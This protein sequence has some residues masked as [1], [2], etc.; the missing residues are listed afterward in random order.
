MLDVAQIVVPYPIPFCTWRCYIDSVQH[1]YIRSPF[2]FGIF[3]AQWINYV[4]Q[5]PNLSQDMMTSSNGN[6]SALR[7]QMETFST[8]LAICAF[9]TVAYHRTSW[10]AVHLTCFCRCSQ[11]RAQAIIRMQTVVCLNLMTKQKTFP[12]L[13]V[14]IHN[15]I[16][17][18]YISIHQ[19]N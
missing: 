10:I 5:L 1:C 9:Q 18:H 14:N 13:T 3:Q 11:L 16:S 8:W 4:S 7:H 12:I 17:Y 2:C 6:I 15:Q 19:F